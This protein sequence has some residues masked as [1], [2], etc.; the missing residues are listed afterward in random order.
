MKKRTRQ[1]ERVRVPA[2]TE[3]RTRRVFE[4][5]PPPTGTRYT[6]TSGGK[7]AFCYFDGLVYVYNNKHYSSLSGAANVAAADLG[8][9]P[10]G[11]NGY[12]WW[13][14]VGVARPGESPW[15]QPV[16]QTET[17]LTPPKPV[18]QLRPVLAQPQ[19]IYR[20]YSREHHENYGEPRES[21]DQPPQSPLPREQRWQPPVEVQ[22][23]PPAPEPRTR[24]RAA[25]SY[26]PS[27][28]AEALMKMIDNGTFTSTRDRDEY[29][30]SYTNSQLEV[31]VLTH[32]TTA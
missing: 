20:E 17:V 26:S 27:E 28:V 19:N 29:V 3:G 21:Y 30:C 18:P 7:T 12:V 1:P 23:P 10:G 16:V 14:M 11:I 6:H 9:S 31:P 24:R 2:A 15:E 8:L 25:D 4:R 13:K 32:A 5:P 22:A